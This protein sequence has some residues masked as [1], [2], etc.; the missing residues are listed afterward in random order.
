MKKVLRIVERMT[1]WYG[2]AMW[3]GPNPK[4]AGELS[5]KT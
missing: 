2:F 1:G 4:I 5:M 3:G